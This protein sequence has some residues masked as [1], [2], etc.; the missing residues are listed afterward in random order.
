MAACVAVLL[1]AGC[2]GAK[3]SVTVTE[4]DDGGA[5]TIREGGTLT[6]ELESNPSTGYSWAV[7]TQ[8]PILTRRG[9]SEFVESES[10]DKVVGAPG[11]ER[12]VFEGAIPGTD[13]L[14]LAYVR[15][16]EITATPENTFKITVSVR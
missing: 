13:V 9:T 12:L 6:V 16:W 1:L 15:S 10:S 3:S 4:K 7:V 8:P 2:A 5:V 11:L 14:E